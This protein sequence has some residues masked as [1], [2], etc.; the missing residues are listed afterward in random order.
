M[1]KPL[2]ILLV[3]DSE[4]D[5]LLLLRELR[6]AGYEP[7]S[8][9]VDTAPA[10]AAALEARQW[11]IVISDYLMPKFGGLA[12]L[13]VLKASG[14]DLPFI[15]VSGNIGEDIAVAAMKAG[16]HDYIIKGNLTR[17]IPAVERELREAENRQDRERAEDQLRHSRQKLF[18]TLENMNE[19]FFTLDNEW[20]FTFV[21]AEASK[22]L[23]KSRPELLGRI[24]WE[25]SP[26]AVGTIFEDQYRKAARERVPV[27]F[28]AL[29][30]LINIWVEVRAHP[31]E[32]GLAVYFHDITERKSAEERISRLNR[33]YSVLSKVNETIIRVHE[34]EELYRMV[35]R[36]AV[37][38]GAFKMAWIGHI[39]PATR[40]VKP[41]A[42]HGDDGYLQDLAICA[43]DVPEGRGPTGRAAFEGSPVVCG[44][45]E[46]D[47]NMLP[48]RDKAL[49]HGLHTSAAF[50]LRTGSEV[51]GVFTIYGGAPK[52]GEAPQPFT[53]EEIALL[54]S[55]AEDIS[56]AIGTMAN[57]RK[58]HEAEQRT[59]I[60]NKLLALYARKIDRKEYIEAAV[61]LLRAWLDC[62][63]GGVRI[64]GRDGYLPFAS[65]VGCEDN[66]P[67]AAGSGASDDSR[68]IC[69]RIASSSPEPQ[70]LPAMTG[71]GSFYSNDMPRF[72]ENLD[73][74]GKERFRS[75][76]AHSNYAS[77]AVVPIR[78]KDSV[79]GAIH[80]A[81]EKTGMV[82]LDKVEVLEYLAHIIGEAILR[83]GIE[84]ELRR[85]NDYNRSLIEAS[86]DPLVTIGQDGKITDVNAATEIAT[87]LTRAELVG[88]D[89]SE[90]FTEPVKAKAAYVMAF[91]EGSFRDY[92]L[93]LRHK[94]GRTTPVLYNASLY[95]DENGKALGVFAAARDVTD[96]REIERRNTVISNLLKL[97]TQTYSR[98]QYLEVAVEIIRSWTGCKSAGMREADREGNIPYVAC[99]GFDSEF[100]AE[101]N[102]VS[103]SRDRCAC[104]RVMAG[105]QAPED[106]V[107]LTPNGSLYYNNAVAYY[108]DLPPE[109]RDR[110]RGVCQRKGFASLAVIPIRYRDRV[111]GILHLADE[112]EGMVTPAKVEF[113]ERVALI[114]GE[115]L[116]R[117]SV[118]EEQVRLASA[119]ESSADAVVI[120]EPVSGMIQYVNRAFERITGY[121]KD[122]AIGRTVHFIE[123]ARRTEEFYRELREA[124][125]QNGVWRGQF[126]NRKKDGG[127]YF[128]DCTY[129]PVRDQSGQIINFISVRRDVTE[130]LRLES[131]AESVNTM[132]NIGYVFSGV[133]HEIGN[134]INSAKMSLS[135]LQHKLDASS[136]EVVRGYVDRAL[137]EIGRVEQLLKNLRNYNLYETP[138]LADLD[139]AAFLDKFLNLISED[140]E[141]KGI[142]IRRETGPDAPW[143]IADPRALQQVLLNIITNAADALA[144]RESPEISLSVMRKY[145]QTLIQVADNGAGMSEQQQQ[146]L[147][148]PFY[149]SKRHGTGLGLVIVK[150]MLT[151]MNGE[152]EITS[153]PGRGTT[154]HITLPEG[155]H[156]AKS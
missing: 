104:T 63:H 119:L 23:K 46:R 142:R 22:V 152:I 52:S 112:R 139:L 10:M 85:A 105:E 149:T 94:D 33:L 77:L 82:P 115:A 90:C 1:S 38:D 156:A 116:Y 56:F 7:V 125:R 87:G 138:E 79:I 51:T 80:F 143:A 11:D 103:L 135:V 137:G 21:N 47:E 108:N 96:L 136:K 122:E 36:I 31:S 88:S 114:I 89:F 144:D 12:A 62:R 97:Y 100:I 58:R 15:I 150:K 117:F 151:K 42:S 61:D 99:A 86:L 72:V 49:L 50:P 78:L 2:N 83:F 44:D 154:V 37:E 91:R 121:T 128:E 73:P 53:G 118:E 64:A 140:F 71:Q 67:A 69:S 28:E 134:P 13:E 101:E 8:E 70:D 76:C 147:F 102:G 131:I 41:V 45:I 141:K 43:A 113:V 132:N 18:V 123:T 17:L 129:S 29:S 9:R 57:E 153:L 84:D 3:E 126:M 146:D 155:T 81:D 32:D 95:R 148:K 27:K 127:L 48:W 20:R 130:K 55:L 106:A 5:A 75:R 110:F 107:A 30:P 93:E 120:T 24:I 16:A 14:L 74:A 68:F 109:Q 40:W 26:G 124:I 66:F 6:R 111:L 59:I 92:A 145:G 34:P 39:D 60:T 25:V 65:C 98:K 19:G 4:D 35:C 133:R 54:S